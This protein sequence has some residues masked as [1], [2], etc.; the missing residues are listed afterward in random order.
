M[1]KYYYIIEDHGFIAEVIDE[2]GKPN[3]YGKP[4]MFSSRE[5]AQKWV[6]K[7]VYKGMS[8]HYIIKEKEEW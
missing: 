1:V 5:Q 3:R 6:D 2:T 4:K 8:F 7:R